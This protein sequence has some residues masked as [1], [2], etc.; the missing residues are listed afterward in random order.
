VLNRC[1]PVAAFALSTLL[2]ACSGRTWSAGIKRDKVAAGYP[3][4]EVADASG[5]RFVHTN[6]MSGEFYFSEIIGSGVALELPILG[7]C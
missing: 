3:F 5:A 1:Y 7:V 6:G 2:M 4:V